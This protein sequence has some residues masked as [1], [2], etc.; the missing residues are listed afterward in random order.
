MY[1]M[2]DIPGEMSVFTEY[3]QYYCAVA[4]CPLLSYPLL[5]ALRG[6][7]PETQKGGERNLLLLNTQI[8]NDAVLEQSYK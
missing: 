3:K 5:Y 7:Q 2:P 8:Q 1:G 6:I 4:G